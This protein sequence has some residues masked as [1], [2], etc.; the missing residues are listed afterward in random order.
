MIHEPDINDHISYRYSTLVDTI[1]KRLKKKRPG[2]HQN[3]S[4]AIESINSLQPLKKKKKFLKPK[5]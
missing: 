2:S 1:G 4:P 5:V 3:Q